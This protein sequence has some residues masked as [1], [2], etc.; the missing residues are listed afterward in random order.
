MSMYQTVHFGTENK[1]TI[2]KLKQKRIFFDI[3]FQ[4][5]LQIYD[6]SM[7]LLIY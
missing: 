4:F 6:K 3:E 5:K 2:Q 1:N 7:E